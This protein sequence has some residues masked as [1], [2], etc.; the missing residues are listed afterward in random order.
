MCEQRVVFR[1]KRESYIKI[2]EE[3]IKSYLIV[4]AEMP[5]SGADRFLVAGSLLCVLTLLGIYQVSAS[6]IYKT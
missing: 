3:T 5:T 4:P 2:A 1:R 6:S